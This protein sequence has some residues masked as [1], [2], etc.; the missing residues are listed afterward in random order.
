MAAVRLTDEESRLPGT[1]HPPP[2]RE[3]QK[4]DKLVSGNPVTVPLPPLGKAF[5]YTLKAHLFFL[6]TTD[7]IKDNKRE[8]KRLPYR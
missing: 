4:L 7:L 6:T 3:P 5:L 2:S 8:A 1:P